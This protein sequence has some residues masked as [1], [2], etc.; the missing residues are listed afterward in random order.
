MREP[1]KSDAAGSLSREQLVQRAYNAAV[2]LLGSRDHS[3]Y[4]LTNKLALREHSAD[5]IQS[6]IE[7]L[8]EL[9]Y[10]NDAR[11]A[12]LY[13]EQRMSRGFGPLSVR[14]KLR[15]RG[16]ALHLIDAALAGFDVSWADLAQAALEHRFDAGVI[17]SREPRDVARISRFLNARG[18]STGDA[19]RA[20]TTA[21]KQSA[22][23]TSK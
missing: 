6:A 14:S 16:I 19:L 17:N 9:N 11:Y 7:E 22:G 8:V 12:Q 4:E 20:L 2:R 13:T 5:A 1:P 15:Q 3:V 18:F 21:R 10:V 23:K